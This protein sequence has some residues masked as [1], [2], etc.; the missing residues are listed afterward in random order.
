M[1]GSEIYD[2][3]GMGPKFDLRRSKLRYG[4]TNLTLRGQ[5]HRVYGHKWDRGVLNVITSL[6][7]GGLVITNIRY[8]GGQVVK[9]GLF[10]IFFKKIRI[11]RK[12]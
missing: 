11:L 5:N 10:L 2:F 3:R 6:L 4:L 12:K 7:M 1:G 8:W 9:I